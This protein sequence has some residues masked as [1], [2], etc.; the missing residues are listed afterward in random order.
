MSTYK[1]YYFNL[2]G[3]AE[4]S[5]LIFAAAGQKYEDVRFEREQ[6]PSLKPQMPLGQAPVL[7]FDGVQLPQSMSIAR[8][9]A[10][11][12][13]LAGKDNFEQA[14]VDAVVDTINDLLTALTPAHREQDETKKQELFK[15]FF[16]EELPKHLQNLDVLGKLYGNGGPYF[17]G[18]HLTWADLLFHVLLETLVGLDGNC[19]NHHPWLKQNRAEVE[20]QPRIAEYLKNRPQTPF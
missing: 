6:W 18:N 3:R 12:F 20:K 2:R 10:K 17:V 1:L 13:Q 7:E 16:A 8:F 9:L 14:K 19:L 5:R 11:Q 4:I 15:N